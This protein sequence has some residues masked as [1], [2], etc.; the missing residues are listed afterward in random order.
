MTKTEEAAAYLGMPIEVA[1]KLRPAI[2]EAVT[3]DDLGAVPPE[4]AEQP[5]WQQASD[6]DR[7]EILR[8]RLF[9]KAAGNPPL[10][11]TE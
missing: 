5:A 9:L 4:M 8:F 11:T 1:A 7:E 3:T 10:T 2:I 6:H